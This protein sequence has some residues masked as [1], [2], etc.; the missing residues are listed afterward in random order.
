AVPRHGGGSVPNHVGQGSGRRSS[1]TPGTHATV[2]RT[3]TRRILSRA[4][5]T[6]APVLIGTCL[7][8][9][10]G[11]A[12]AGEPRTGPP[13]NEVAPSIKGSPRDGAK[14]KAARGTWVGAKGITYAYQWQRCNS[15]GGECKNIGGATQTSYRVTPEDVGKTLR[16]AITATNPE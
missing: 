8:G 4:L 15:S 5:G 11:S 3:Y 13:V 9:G 10:V 12:A 2:G 1:G 6:L 7:L 14:V 16:V